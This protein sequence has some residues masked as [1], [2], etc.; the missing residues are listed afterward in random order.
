[1]IPGDKLLAVPL[2]KGIFS[3]KV[4]MGEDLMGFGAEIGAGEAKWPVKEIWELQ[5]GELRCEERRGSFR[6]FCP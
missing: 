4:A 3:C 5:M 6:C 1:L 2:I